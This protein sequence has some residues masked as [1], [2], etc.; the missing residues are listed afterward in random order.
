MRVKENVLK[1]CGRVPEH[2]QHS[3]NGSYLL[4]RKSDSSSSQLDIGWVTALQ[5]QVEGGWGSFI[6]YEAP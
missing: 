6:S 5:H 1:V 4:L 3:V 2:S